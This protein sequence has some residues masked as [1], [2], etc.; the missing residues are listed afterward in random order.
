VRKSLAELGAGRSIVLDKH[1]RII[2]GNKTAEQAGKAGISRVI[3]VRTDGTELVAVQRTDLDLEQDQ[4]AK[5]LAV[6]DNRTAELG[7]DWD[8]DVLKAISGE[9]DLSGLFD[10]AE[11]AELITI[12]GGG[13]VENEDEAPDPPA[14][15]VS[16]PGDLFEMGKHRLLCGDATRREDVARLMGGAKAH[17]VFTDPPY[18]ISVQMNNPGT[19]CKG[20]IA[21]DE[22]T[23]AAVAAFEYC[24]A[25]NIPTIFWG[26]NHYTADAKLPNAKCWIC[27]DKQEAEN[28]IDQA[29][30]EFA[31]SNIDQPARVFH[32]LWSGFRRDSEKGER[33]VHPTQKPVALIEAIFAQ[34]KAGK[35]VL[36]LF[37]GSGSTL[38][39]CEKTD[40]ACRVME[41]DPVFVDVI[42]ARWEAFTGRKAKRLTA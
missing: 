32:H 36:D 25:L 38:M 28:H 37:G 30:C 26:A 18:G 39:A 29:D 14:V 42:V 7:L 19:V 24:A 3:V 11:L 9:V 15:A 20:K 5:L 27:W 40:R 6:A 4:R 13:I 41:I 31:W 12:T 2:A 21:G 8:V 35:I 34:F 22:T 16:K 17:M 10:E 1:G 23:A 33:R